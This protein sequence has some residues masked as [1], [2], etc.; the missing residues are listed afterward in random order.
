[1]VA[2]DLLTEL[3]PGRQYV[4]ASQDFE[5]LVGYGLSPHK[6]RL[7]HANC[8]PVSLVPLIPV[9]MGRGRVEGGPLLRHPLDFF[10]ALIA[11]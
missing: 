3:H 5:P 10:W 1:M 6:G 7:V 4:K 2:D 8:Q 9:Y 11:G